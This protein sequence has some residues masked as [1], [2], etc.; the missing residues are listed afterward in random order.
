MNRPDDLPLQEQISAAA[1]E[2]RTRRALLYMLEDLQRERIVIGQARRDWIDTVDAIADPLMVLDAELRVV[3]C[4]SAYVERARMDFAEIL[5]RP[6]WECF[7][8]RSGPLEACPPQLAA[9]AK[10]A[11]ETEIRLDTGEIFVSRAYAIGEGDGYVLHLFENV[12]VRRATEQAVR[13]AGDAVEGRERF[14]RKLIEGSSDAFFVIDETGVVKYRSE[15]GKRLTGYD[16]ADV[17]GR[18]LMTLVLPESLDEAGRTLSEVVTQP[19]RTLLAALRIRRKDG[20]VIDVEAAGRNLLGDPDVNGI[21]VTARDITERAHIERER[22][23]TNAVLVTQQETSLDGIYVVDENRKMISWNRRFVE[24][25]GLSDEVVASGS[26]ELALQSVLDNFESPD[27]FLDGVKQLFANKLQKI[28]D[29]V[30]LKDGRTFARYSSPMIGVAGQYYGRVFYFRDV[31]ENRAAARALR[32]SEER[33]RAIFENTIDG[34][35]VMDIEKRS[36]AFANGSMAR[37]LGY[38]P[39]AL[40]DV[41]IAQ[42]MAPEVAEHSNDQ[43]D[44]AAR[45]ELSLV[46]DLRLHRRDDTVVYVDVTGAPVELA[47]RRYLLAS[48]RDATRR[49]AGEEALR[50][51]LQELQRWQGLNLDREDRVIELKCEVNEMMTQL[52]LPPRYAAGA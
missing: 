52:N 19:G 18:P 43:F 21:V 44:S 39:G 27:D 10:D 11:H 16:T 14:Y 8:K 26:D 33:F 5:G 34:I 49:R 6:Y 20:A 4:N 51:Q 50:A 24:M 45:G 32:E 35:L 37:M 41:P 25:W 23:F 38:G 7:P 29:E 13:Q 28:Q 40:A 30:H 2:T 9:G 47:G 17:M 46:Q 31:S 42:L 22:Q 48:V 15:S 12:T 1:D 36:V 3:R